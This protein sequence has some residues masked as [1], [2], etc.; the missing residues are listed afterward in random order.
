VCASRPRSSLLALVALLA[1]LAGGSGAPPPASAHDAP[2]PAGARH[3]LLPDEHWVMAHQSPFD[4]RV[5]TDALRMPP[6][7]LEAFLYNDHH[8]IAQLARRRH[9]GFTGLVRRLTAWTATV[10]GA[11][12]AEMER[13][14]RLV[15]V[16]GHLAQHVFHHVF[17]G[18]DLLPRVVRAADVRWATFDDR[19]TR[20]WSLRRIVSSAGGDPAAVE[21]DLGAA[22][23]AEH[24]RGVAE[25]QTPASQAA[26]MAARQHGRLHCWFVRPA[27]ALDPSAPYDRGYTKHAASHTSRDVP[28]T[29]AEQAVEDRAIA[30]GLAG[31]PVG[32]WGRPQRFRGDPGAP[33]SRRRLRVLGG[34]PS[35]FKGPVN[36]GEHHREH[37]MAG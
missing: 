32:C 24:D 29:R 30:R 3:G 31:R 35:G 17:H 8:T 27:Q 16:S 20:R 19:R 25:A 6:A 26:R 7:Q 2:M 28:T 21:R 12:R 36:D 23:D 18:F 11:D 5:L 15:L 14:T 9:V 4:E 37:R 10:P 13:R 1:A 22:I 34:V 33:L